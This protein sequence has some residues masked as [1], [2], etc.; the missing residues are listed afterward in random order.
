MNHSKSQSV[1]WT[2]FFGAA[3]ATMLCIIGI[4]LMYFNAFTSPISLHLDQ[5]MELRNSLDTFEQQM[6]VTTS[7]ANLTATFEKYLMYFNIIAAIISVL[8]WLGFIQVSAFS[9]N[10]SNLNGSNAGTFFKK[11]KNKHYNLLSNKEDKFEGTD[12]KSLNNLTQ[13]LT[14]HKSISSWTMELNDDI[15]MVSEKLTLLSNETVKLKSKQKHEKL[16]W[17]DSLTNLR[18]VKKTLELISSNFSTVIEQNDALTDILNISTKSEST[19][20]NHLKNITESNL[21]VE[22]CSNNCISTIT[23]T[24]GSID[25]VLTDVSSAGKIVEHLSGKAQKIVGIIDVVGDIAEQTNLLA[26]N[27]SIEA[28]R[29]GEQG[30]GFAVV[31]EE[32]RKLAVRSQSIGVT[33]IDL[34]NSLIEDGSQASNHLKECLSSTQVAKDNLSN[35]T[36]YIRQVKSQI[37]GITDITTS[38]TNDKQ[39]LDQS[40]DNIR[41]INSNI[42]SQL[43]GI[44]SKSLHNTISYANITN[45]LNNLSK[46][47]DFK[48][49][50][51]SQQTL[52]TNLV[53]N[54]LGNIKVTFNEITKEIHANTEVIAEAK[55]TLLSS[56]M[57]IKDHNI[58]T[59]NNSHYHTPVLPHN[60]AS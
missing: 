47:C 9:T 53:K 59:L 35:V 28:A 20:D 58:E 23:E 41:I 5:L 55:G 30:K 6:L 40:Y 38:M 13:A 18:D 54:I 7:V 50:S 56:H 31:A 1:W 45:S 32:V 57:N 49:Q 60:E 37:E 17:T 16:E 21:S 36:D 25:G 44:H 19:I 4:D 33:I 22:L 27:A 51:L 34:L 43:K 24:N 11:R 8:S 10:N 39:A 12:N 3:I 2:T 42:S 14:S 26:L 29:A 15:N 48:G 46:N 52:N